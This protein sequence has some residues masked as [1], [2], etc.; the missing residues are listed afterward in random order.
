MFPKGEFDGIVAGSP[1]VNFNNLYSWRGRFFTVTGAADSANFIQADTWRNLIHPEILK[2]CD[3]I[4]GAADGII[5]D[6]SLCDFNPETVLC[7]DP[8]ET[9]TNGTCLNEAQV[10]IVR[11]I[12]SPYTYPN[13]TVIYPGMQPGGELMA[14]QRLY[15]GVP[16]PYS[17]DWFRYVVH[18]D[19]TW[20]PASFNIN[21]TI[22]AI[23]MNPGNVRTYPSDLSPFRDSGGKIISFHGGQDS[24]ISGF[25]TERFYNHLLEGMS[26]TP[27][28]LDQFYRFFRIEGMFHCSG[29]PGAW[30]LGQGG[31]TSAAG[32][33]FEPESNVLAAVV[34]WVENGTAPEVLRGTKFVNDTIGLGVDYV[35]DHCRYPLR[36]T[37]TG[38]DPKA[39]E[40][41]ECRQ[42]A[43]K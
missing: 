29:G 40:S 8:D 37:F 39:A 32:I 21:D 3:D 22:L 12:F 25:N 1:A 42:V 14:V 23:D 43:E 41:W 31:G 28:D 18:S 20:D 15:A 19:P 2:Q 6:P 7:A 10:S 4:D 35:K 11:T 16:F 36:N 26:A 5:T 13:G 34:A 24:Q 17:Q 27:T 33:P 38:G 9:S 30:V